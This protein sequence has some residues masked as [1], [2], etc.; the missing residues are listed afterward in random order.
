MNRVQWIALLLSL[1]CCVGQTPRAAAQTEQPMIWVEDCIPGTYKDSL[2]GWWRGNLEGYTDKASVKQGETISFKVS[3][4]KGGTDITPGTYAIDIYRVG[5]STTSDSLIDDTLPDATSSFQPLHGSNGAPIYPWQG[6]PNGPFPMEYCNGCDSYN[7]PVAFS[8]T[9]P[10]SWPSGFYYALLTM[11]S[12]TGRVPFVVKEDSPGSTGKILCVIAWNTYQAYN[13]WGGGSLYWCIGLFES[14]ESNPNGQVIR[15]VSFKRPFGLHHHFADTWCGPDH[16]YNFVDQLGQLHHRERDFINWAESNGYK[17][18]Y[19]VDLDVH[20]PIG[21]LSF[22]NSYKAVVFPGHS[23]YWSRQ[24]RLNVEAYRNSGGNL[25]FFAAN[26]CYWKVDFQ[27]N[28]TKMYCAKD[29]LAWWWRNQPEGPESKVIGVLFGGLNVL[30]PGNGVNSEQVVT[31]ASHWIFSGT[32]LSNGSLFGYGDGNTNS[33]PDV[34]IDPMASGEADMRGTQNPPN[35]SVEVLARVYLRDLVS[36][37]PHFGDPALLFNDEL[38]S[39]VTYYEDNVSNARVFA[40]GGHEWAPCL[41][42]T[43]ATTMSTITKNLLD[44]FSYK[45]Y[46]GNI[47]AQFLT[48]GDE[49]LETATILDGD[50]Y[51]LAGKTLSL[52]NNFLLTL[53]PGVT[54]YVQGTLVIGSNVTITGGGKIVTSGSGLIKT[55]NNTS[56]ATAFNNSRKIAQDASGNSLYAS[57]F[58]S[59]R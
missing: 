58:N 50:T 26:N 22:L 27:A 29:S 11:G 1:V 5:K 48:W 40:A 13:Y 38:Y 32:G 33:C 46:R 51:I 41:F 19:A 36:G 10:S 17:I 43:D 7:W 2:A 3:V 14:P 45:K 56:L 53:N 20:D 25:A 35:A 57:N 47:Y 49:T 31:N 24:Q 37:E 30:A 15:T 8:K 9:I 12:L 28:D 39:E 4:W 16:R 42:G 44:H 55:E 6:G 18:E 52:T 23:E 34:N 59:R 54:L 21:G